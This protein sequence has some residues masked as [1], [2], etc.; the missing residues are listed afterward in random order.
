M[1]I[2]VWFDSSSSQISF[3]RKVNKLWRLRRHNWKQMFAKSKWAAISHWL[4]KT[5]PLNNFPLLLFV[6]AGSAKT[7]WR[8]N[9]FTPPVTFWEVWSLFKNSDTRS[10][11]HSAK[12]KNTSRSHSQVSFCNSSSLWKNCDHPVVICHFATRNWNTYTNQTTLL[13]C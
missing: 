5:F 4:A 8:W 6:P 12:G 7:F 11:C 9:G 10:V 3:F 1:N 2:M 13:V